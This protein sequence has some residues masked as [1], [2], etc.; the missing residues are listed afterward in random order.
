MQLDMV[1][2][3]PVP[4]QAHQEQ[5]YAADALQLYLLQPQPGSSCTPTATT[6]NRQ[7][8]QAKSAKSN[9]TSRK[10]QVIETK[11]FLVPTTQMNYHTKWQQRLVLGQPAQDILCLGACTKWLWWQQTRL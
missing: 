6:R 8:P 2:H 10:L 9:V 5:Q 3:L 4:N 1:N 11:E 7:Q